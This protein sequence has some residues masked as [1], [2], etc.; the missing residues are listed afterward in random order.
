MR[1][2]HLSYR[3]AH[4]EATFRDL[5]RDRRELGQEPVSRTPQPDLAESFYHHPRTSR[6]NRICR[7]FLGN[8]S[9]QQ[10]Q[11]RNCAA[12]RTAQ[13]GRPRLHNREGSTHNRHRQTAPL[14]Q[15]RDEVAGSRA[16]LIM[17]QRRAQPSFDTP[18]LC[19][20]ERLSRHARI[21]R[22]LNTLESKH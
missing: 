14:N 21:L 18:E 17:P 11:A 19:S 3:P 13:C 12:Q 20:S 6:N 10:I 5:Q 16:P 8:K 7:S 9:R 15:E 4:A 22:V 2:N 1:S